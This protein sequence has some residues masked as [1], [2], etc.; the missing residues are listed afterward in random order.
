LKNKI[1]RSCRGLPLY[2]Y[3][4]ETFYGGDQRGYPNSDP[5]AIE[6]EIGLHSG[7]TKPS[8]LDAKALEILSEDFRHAGYLRTNQT[9]TVAIRE[10]KQEGRQIVLVFSADL[11]PI[12]GPATVF[13]PKV[14]APKNTH[15]VDYEYLLGRRRLDENAQGAP[16]TIHEKVKDQ[17]KIKYAIQNGAEIDIADDHVWP[18]PVTDYVIRF[19]RKAHY[20]FEVFKRIMPIEKEPVP[21]G[22]LI[23]LAREAESRNAS[24]S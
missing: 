18:G 5:S 4:R 3:D 21:V 1:L 16:E 10:S 17:L 19:K 20:R 23:R 7:A 14:K 9:M 24:A 22:N 11:I 13:A 15:L 8:Y 12:E 6:R 2:P